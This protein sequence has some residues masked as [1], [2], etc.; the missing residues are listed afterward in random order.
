[1]FWDWW[2]YCQMN[3]LIASFIPAIQS[4]SMQTQI[5]PTESS[6]IAVTWLL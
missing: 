3:K 5:M 1:M 2:D 6:T 4:S